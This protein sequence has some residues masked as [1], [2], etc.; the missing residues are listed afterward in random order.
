NALKKTAIAI[1]GQAAKKYDKALENEQ[2]L[3]ARIADMMMAIF[4]AESAILRTAK[5]HAAGKDSELFQALAQAY[6][7]GA[8]EK[9]TASAR[10]ALSLF[11]QGEA[12]HKQL[13]ALAKIQSQP[14]NSIAL[15]RTVA[16]AVLKVTGYPVV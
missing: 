9:C 5:L 7:A 13:A 1:L 8:V 16:D 12:L 4:A 10:E 2:E 11:V 14:V 3:L 15:R 6:A